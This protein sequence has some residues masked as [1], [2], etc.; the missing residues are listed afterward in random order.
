MMPTGKN[1]DK[2]LQGQNVI[3]GIPTLCIPNESETTGTKQI[4]QR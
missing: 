2:Y 3:D 1:K 4:I